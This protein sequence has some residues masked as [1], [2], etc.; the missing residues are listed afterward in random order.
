MDT[1][2]ILFDSDTSQTV[3]VA[4]SRPATAL[5]LKLIVNAYR[6]VPLCLPLFAI[7]TAI[8]LSS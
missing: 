7:C 2:R 8:F 5:D 6:T 4:P 3:F 1:R